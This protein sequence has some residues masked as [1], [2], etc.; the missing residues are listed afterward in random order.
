[1][2]CE[3]SSAQVANAVMCATLFVCP[4]R[5]WVQSHPPPPCCIQKDI[6][7]HYLSLQSPSSKRKATSQQS[8]KQGCAGVTCIRYAHRWVH[9]EWCMQ[10]E[11]K[12][13]DADISIHHPPPPPPPPTHPPTLTRGNPVTC[14]PARN[15]WEWKCVVQCMCI[16]CQFL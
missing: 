3:S 13:A 5:I 15:R 10:R 7:Y 14:D 6:R 9:S 1:M 2:N 11:R 12:W 8:S 16:M 4:L